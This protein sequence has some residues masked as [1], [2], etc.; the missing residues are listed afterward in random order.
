MRILEKLGAQWRMPARTA[1]LRLAMLVLAVIA[2]VSA[3]SAQGP[4]LVGSTSW[5]HEEPQSNRGL[6]YDGTY[7][8]IGQIVKNPRI[9]IYSDTGFIKSI[10]VPAGVDWLFPHGVAVDGHQ[11]KIWATD[12]FGRTIFEFDFATGSLIRKIPSP[13]PANPLRLAY[14]PVSQTLWM[15][16]YGN[17]RVYNVSLQGTILSSFTTSGYGVGKA[18]AVDGSGSL[19]V[20]DG[21]NGGDGGVTLLRRYSPTGAVL[22]EFPD[23]GSQWDIATNV[24]DRDA[25]FFRTGPAFFNPATGRDEYRIEHYAFGEPFQAMRVV[26]VDLSY[27]PPPAQSVNPAGFETLAIAGIIR[28]GAGSDGIDPPAEQ[29]TLAVGDWSATLPAGSFVVRE[30]GAWGFNGPAG[31]AHL[32][33]CLTPRTDGGYAYHIQLKRRLPARFDN[34]VRV[35]IAIGDDH[36]ETSKTVYGTLTKEPTSTA[37]GGS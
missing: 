14:D 11:Q 13:I 27:A 16:G 4:I 6:A 9:D 33:I 2:S 8:Y 19:L 12:Y 24:N 3:A 30:S 23:F 26:K 34:P 5:S 21:E 37:G 17:P 31:G 15:T 35:K 1:A 22:E 10:P 25:G 28:P 7:Y 18:I 36:G 32:G 29:V 20:G